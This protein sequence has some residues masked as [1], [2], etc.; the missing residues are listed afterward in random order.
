MNKKKWPFK[1]FPY[2]EVCCPCCGALP[3]AAYASIA[4][5]QWVR[6]KLGIPVVMNSAH[7]CWLKNALVGGAPLSMHKMVIA[8]D[9]SM[10]GKN[11]KERLKIVKVCKEAGFTGFG[12]YKTFLHVDCGRPRFWYGRGAKASW[13][14]NG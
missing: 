6:E 3:K 13:Q 5:A 12:Y 8:F 10:R 2:R 9:I 14:W 4:K 7:R 11:K 1:N